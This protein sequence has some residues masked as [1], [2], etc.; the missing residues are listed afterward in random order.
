MT[1]KVPV[2]HCVF[3]EIAAAIKTC[4]DQADI[5]GLNAMI[6]L[7]LAITLG[8]PV[9]AFVAAALAAGI[10]MSLLANGLTFIVVVGF[11]IAAVFEIR[12]I[13]DEP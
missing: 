1:T 11:V 2:P 6:S 10:N 9:L 4:D 12:R 7:I 13:A 8:L 3:I 5:T